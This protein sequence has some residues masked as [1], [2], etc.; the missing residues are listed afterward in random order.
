MKQKFLLLSAMLL[1]SICASAQNFTANWEKPAAPAFDGTFADNT[2]FYLWN[3]GAGGFFTCH[4]GGDGSPYWGTRASVNDTIGN[5]VNFTLDNPTN[6]YEE[7][8]AKWLQENGV[9]DVW[10]LTNYVNNRGFNK[11]MCMFAGGYDDIW[12]DNDGRNDRF[13]HVVKSGNNIKIEGFKQLNFSADDLAAEVA[14]EKTLYDYEGKYLGVRA[15]N[16]DRVLFLY[17][18]AAGKIGADEAFYDEWA[19]VT[20]ET[21]EAYIAT[22]DHEMVRKYAL[23][24]NLRRA[25]ENAYANFPTINLDPEVDV[26]NNTS[27]T[28]AELTA[29]ITKVD[30][31]VALGTAIEK[32]ENAVADIYLEDQKGVFQNFA[33]T[34]D[35]L[36]AATDYVNAK[37]ALGADLQKALEENPGIDL[38][39]V[40]SVYNNASST[41]AEMEAAQQAIVAAVLEYGA[42]H[43]TPDNPVNFTASIVNPTFDTIGDFHGWSGTAFGAGG[44]TS[45]SAEHYGHNFDTYQDIDLTGYPGVYAVKV[46]GYYRQTDSQTAWN[47]FE[48]EGEDTKACLYISSASF[49]EMTTP[50]KNICAGAL[51]YNPGTG[52]SEVFDSFGTPHYIPNTMLS[53]TTTFFSMDP[54]PYQVMAINAVV[55]GEK[56]RIGVRNQS[57]SGSCWTNFDDFE[58]WYYGNSAEAYAAIKENLLATTAIEIPE[59][60]HYGQPDLDAYNNAIEALKNAGNA[61]DIA[62]AVKAVTTA[63]T[64][65]EKSISAYAA[66]LAQIEAAEQ[67]LLDSD[68]AFGED[69]DKLADYLQTAA[70][71]NDEMADYEFPNGV[72]NFIIDLDNH[73]LVGKL[74][75]AEIE[76]E[77]AYLFELLQTAIRNSLHSGSDLTYMIKNPGFDDDKDINSGAAEG[78][79]IE[80]GTGGNITRGPLGQDNK[81][82]MESALGKM[83]YCFEAWHRYNWDVW[84]EITDLPAGI[85]ELSVQ[86]YVR[87]EVNGYNRGEDIN[88]NYPSPV[89]LYM[90]NAMSQFPSVYSE[91]AADKGHDFTTVEGWTT[92]DVGGNLYPNSMGG[93]AQCF[94]WGMYTTKAYGFVEEDGGS[95]RIGVKMKGNQDWWCIWDNFQLKFVG[96]DVA[97]MQSIIADYN[98]RVVTMKE[99]IDAGDIVVGDPEMGALE[100]AK[101]TALQAKEADPMY[102]ALLALVAAYNEAKNS[103]DLYAEVNTL[104]EYYNDKVYSEDFGEVGDYQAV[105]DALDYF[106]TVFQNIPFNHTMSN[107]EVQEAIDK[108]AALYEEALVPADID[109]ASP[110]NP[111]K[112][113]IITN[114]TFDTIGDFTGWSSGF[115]AG[116]ATGPSAE[117]WQNAFDVYQDVTVPRLGTYEVRVNGAYRDGWAENDYSSW[118]SG[119]STETYFYAKTK[120]AQ[121]SCLVNHNCEGGRTTADW[122]SKNANPN[123]ADNPW[124]I[125][126]S[127]AEFDLYFHPTDEMGEP[128]DSPYLIK[129]VINVTE[130]DDDMV[131]RIGVKRDE[132]KDGG[133]AIFDDFEIYF[134]GLN[135]ASNSGDALP[136]ESI[137]T[138]EKAAVVAVYTVGGTRLA[139]L[140]RGI[141]IVRMSDGSV[142]KI[143]VK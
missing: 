113:E 115:G 70:I 92:E 112:L 65:F 87:C 120:T 13:W 71:D 81:N 123:D 133:W 51:D 119:N 139:T 75:A 141:N 24:Q 134:L 103:A 98:E 12:C 121:V 6:G 84:Q 19:I 97:A 122:A 11:F 67:W 1:M 59:G 23:A 109:D 7:T 135:G 88:P 8:A 138:S 79:T 104:Y 111:K 114:A 110:E 90:N 21:Y 101:T 41:I 25:I 16:A 33:S 26:Y 18:T 143:I 77:T 99:Q 5:L 63:Q 85:Y 106:E 91:C 137:S 2:E 140:Q 27:S 129:N 43:A 39:A 15:N 126:D 57:M 34:L 136:V 58:L 38:T 64:N 131:I 78:W 94:G 14:G 60:A 20:P 40:T 55:D 66:Y 30:A 125:A 74:S 50:I 28:E 116:G 4:Q 117:V 102:N 56:L 45:T 124:Y 29:A 36:K 73:A 100:A 53:A 31:F 95:F 93:A 96:K 61:E 82:L 17:D 54:C 44:T 35:E 69:V 118:K 47:H 10:L 80:A 9:S 128:I 48:E 127:M 142:R 86:G 22:V 49:G 132:Y 83:N 105:Q 108:M 37:A 52:E 3:V 76:T 72:A 89:Y 42:Q 68:D 107:A 62:A 32:A 46:K 130:A